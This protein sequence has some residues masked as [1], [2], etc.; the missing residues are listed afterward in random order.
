MVTLSEFVCC[1][2]F[3]GFF[4]VLIVSYIFMHIRE[5]RQDEWTLSFFVMGLLFVLTVLGI[6]I[7]AYTTG[8]VAT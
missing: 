7:H 6:A 4:L 5:K 1:I 8:G 3:M 2:L